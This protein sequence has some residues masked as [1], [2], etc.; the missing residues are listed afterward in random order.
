MVPKTSLKIRIPIL[1]ITLV[2]VFTIAC[3]AQPPI[4]GAG[5]STPTAAASQTPNAT[6]LYQRTLQANQ[7]QNALRVSTQAAFLTQVAETASARAL[8]PAATSTPTVSP[9]LMT[10]SRMPIADAADYELAEPDAKALV[11]IIRSALQQYHENEYC[12]DLPA[13][14]T[15][16][17]KAA[18][19]NESLSI[20]R[21]ADETVDR[22]AP[23]DLGEAFM[24]QADR[25]K[26]YTLF[27]FVL[28][29]TTRIGLTSFMVDY[30]N[31][32]KTIL[33]GGQK[34]TN[35]FFSASV[36]MAELDGDANPEWLLKTYFESFN[37]LFLTLLDESPTGIFQSIPTPFGSNP[38]YFLDQEEFFFKDVTGD[39]ND[40]VIIITEDYFGGG[41]NA[42][43]FTVFTF[44]DSSFRLLSTIDASYSGFSQ[45]QNSY[46]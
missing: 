38:T 6:Q 32:N 43:L 31:E 27:N 26:D 45:Y 41:W 19:K 5:T 33:D 28:N 30:L 34:I 15:C 36:Q 23:M 35:P 39:G 10:T 21:F 40:E 1:V 11:D 7:T 2:A 9:T 44:E 37:F 16:R 14:S 24:S 8:T 42:L 3:T 13:D 29:E 46:E 22:S 4:A 17:Y 12:E 20:M 25:F 18:L